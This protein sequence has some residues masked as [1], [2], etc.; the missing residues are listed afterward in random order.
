MFGEKIRKR[1]DKEKMK[2]N[3]KTERKG[4]Q[5]MERLK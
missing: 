5:V 4:E 2:E 3:G 1:E